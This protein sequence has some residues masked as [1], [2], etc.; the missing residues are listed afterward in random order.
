LWK[1]LTKGG[2]AMKKG[3]GIFLVVA[4]LLGGASAAMAM[5]A[6]FGELYYDDTIVRTVVPPATMSK[7]GRD[8]FYGVMGGHPDQKGI[9][10]VAPGDKGYHG[11]KWAFHKVTWADG[12]TPYLLTS[13]DAVMDAETAEDVVVERIPAMD[14]KC[15]IQP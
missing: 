3:L 5:G 13:E 12:V 4:A 10:A 2:I 8:A 6:M 9:A 11:G 14:F 1:L 7:V 15:P